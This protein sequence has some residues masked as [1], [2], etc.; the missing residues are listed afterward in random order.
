MY[1]RRLTVNDATFDLNSNKM[2]YLRTNTIYNNNPTDIAALLSSYVTQRH[3][4]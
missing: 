4:H 3:H 2:R 1:S